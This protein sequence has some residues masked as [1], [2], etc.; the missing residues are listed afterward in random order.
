MKILI[1]E[2]QYRLILEDKNLWL[3]RRISEIEDFVDLALRRVSP[4][5]YTYHEYVD[6]I[7]WQVVDEYG[8]MNSHNVDLLMDYVR[9]QYWKKIEKH[10]LNSND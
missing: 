6:E 7:A 3:L 10:Y 4:D 5:G 2:R 9:E 8:N 1:T